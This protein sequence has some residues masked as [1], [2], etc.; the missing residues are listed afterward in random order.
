MKKPTTLENHH[1]LSESLSNI[2]SAECENTRSKGYLRDI[3]KYFYNIDKNVKSNFPNL[4]LGINEKELEKNE[5]IDRLSK[6]IEMLKSQ[7][8]KKWAIFLFLIF[9]PI[10]WK[11]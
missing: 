7:I 10:S 8:I 4:K 5:E 1:F 2:K 6:R 9:R 3:Q 11:E